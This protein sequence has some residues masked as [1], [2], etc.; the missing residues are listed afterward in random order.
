MKKLLAFII[1]LLLIASS[2]AVAEDAADIRN[3][4]IKI[5]HAMASTHPIQK[6]LDAFKEDI[7]TK[8]QGKIK[9]EL[10]SDAVLG[11]D[12]S[13]LDQIRMGTLDAAVVTGGPSWFQGSD[14]RGAIEELPFLFSSAAEARAAYGGAFG[15]Y[16]AKEI[17]EPFDVHVVCFLE[18]GFR[19]FSSNIR[20]IVLPTDMA[21]QK[22][23]IAP[24]TLRLKTFEAL[25]ASAISMS[26]SELYT[27]LQQGTVDAQENPLTMIIAGK[28]YEV[29]KYV[30][31]SGHIWNTAF[32]G[33]N[34]KFWNTL[35]EAEQKLFT[36]AAVAAREKLYQMDD[37]EWAN[38]VA[39]LEQQ[40]IAVNEVDHDA[41]VEAV[42][43]VWDYF[44]ENCGDELIK[45]ALGQE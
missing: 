11:D 10:Y 43:P 27:A 9:I 20:P 28:L 6:M 41:F 3:M 33:F 40:G 32:L 31:L 16:I 19:H 26:F 24:S 42:Q 13:L 4:T 39:F 36:D 23:R 30:S 12:S 15:E 7:E 18:S 29:Q 37:E 17:M 25:N 38:A 35:S 34:Q 2:F 21:G 22:F 44:R 14:P 8:S 1:S 45:L 5:P